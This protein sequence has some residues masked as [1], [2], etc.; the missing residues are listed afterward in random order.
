[1]LKVPAWTVFKGAFLFLIAM[2]VCVAILIAFAK[3]VLFLPNQ[4][5]PIDR[6]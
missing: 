2:I 1:M 3:I 5:M 4:I 6:G